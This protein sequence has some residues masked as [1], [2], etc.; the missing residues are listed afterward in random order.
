[1]TENDSLEKFSKA[2]LSYSRMGCKEQII[3]SLLIRANLAGDGIKKVKL[4]CEAAMLTEDKEK[5]IDQDMIL[6]LYTVA[7]SLETFIKNKNGGITISWSFPQTEENY[8]KFLEPWHKIKLS[9]YPLFTSMA[10]KILV[11]TDNSFSSPSE[12]YQQQ[13]KS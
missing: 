4:I 6:D 10:Y 12:I 9:Y 11:P 2:A 8:V 3:S 7:S 1:M 13:K 5:K